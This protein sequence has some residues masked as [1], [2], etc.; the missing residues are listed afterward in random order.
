VIPVELRAPIVAWLPL[1]A[2]PGD[3]RSVPDGPLRF[4]PAELELRLPRSGDS[5]DC[6]LAA[7]AS[8]SRTSPNP[9]A[10]HS[11]TIAR[12]LS[13]NRARVRL[14]T[15]AGCTRSRSP[16]GTIEARSMERLTV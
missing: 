3:R 15:V 11:N 13:D 5:E 8:D 1:F 6:V 10:A 16:S 4:E 9:P 2:D 7:W 12:R 14:P